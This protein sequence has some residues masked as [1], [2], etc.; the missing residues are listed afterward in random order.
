M[1][2]FNFI[3]SAQR[4]IATEAAAVTALQHS[5]DSSFEKACEII[6]A[7]KGRTI[8]TGIGKSG[9]I[10]RKIAA[11]LTSTGTPA[12]FMHPSE[13]SHGD[14]GMVTA[15][16]VLIAISYSGAS[17]EILTLL[18]QLKRLGVPVISMTGTLGSP[19]AETANAHLNIQVEREA[20]PLA[21]A[22]TS[23]TS[24][25]VVMGDALA[26]ALLDARGFTEADFAL[27]HPGGALGRKLLLKVCDIMHVDKEI[28][29]VGADDRLVDALIVMTNKSFGLTT[30]VD[31]AGK[32]LGIYTDGDLRRTIDQGTDINTAIMKNIMSQ[33]PRTILKDMLAFDALKTMQERKITALIIEDEHNHPIGVI[34]MHDLLRAGVV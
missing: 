10:G 17:A 9:H 11:T 3:A 27:S 16:D 22:P 2:K 32:L 15:D 26:I 1:T 29:K 6:L 34:H 20:C 12:F 8:V 4:T 21:L 19:L 14:I 33:N 23:S 30:I 25:T 24:V 28:P 13:A 31:D 7:C 18:P 5:I